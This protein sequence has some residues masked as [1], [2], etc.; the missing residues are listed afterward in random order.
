MIIH[1]YK[2]Y[3][4]ASTDEILYKALIETKLFDEIK[5]GRF[6]EIQMEMGDILNI[7]PDGTMVY[8]CFTLIMGAAMVR[9]SDAL[10]KKIKGMRINTK[11]VFIKIVDIY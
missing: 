11:L 9:L 1:K 10:I 3:V 6:E 7:L 4:Y 8:T 5:Q 2:L